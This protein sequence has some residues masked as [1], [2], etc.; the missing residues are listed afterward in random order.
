MNVNYHP[1]EELLFDYSSGALQEP[2][3]IAVASHLSF[4]PKCRQVVAE[5]EAIGGSLLENITPKSLD[6]SISVKGFAGLKN[7]M[8]K[9]SFNS[10]SKD[11]VP[12]DNL[13][14]APL[15]KYIGCNFNE[16][17]W[18]RLGKGIFQSLIET[19]EETATAR[20]LKVPAG[21]MVPEHSHKGRE[22]TLVLSGA[23]EDTTGQYNRGD[24]QEAD[25]SLMH[26]PRALAGEPCVCLVI[27]DAPLSFRN[28]AIKAV[29]PMLGI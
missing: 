18:G 7:Y 4:C 16:I 14:P 20:L 5:M 21:S 26:Q 25:E 8:Q 15:R 28:I 10:T 17:K 19:K 11:L 6:T 23:F 3:S 22:L 12:S 24:L 29:Q 9:E 13:I 27:T 1:S 2:W